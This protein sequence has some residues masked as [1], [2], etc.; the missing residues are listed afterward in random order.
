MLKEVTVTPAALTCNYLL[1]L[2][3]V[4]CLIQSNSP[5]LGAAI[6]ACALKELPSQTA[7]FSM[8]VMVT[9]N[10]QSSVEPHFRGLHHLVIATFGPETIFVFD[11][12]RRNIVATIP[13]K[14]ATDSKFWSEL[15]LPIAIGVLGAAVGVVPVHCACLSLE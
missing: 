9:E 14:L 13:L 1:Q 10:S 4:S 12:L 3:G 5:A 11:I 15:L 8:Q 6:E 2:A 7:A